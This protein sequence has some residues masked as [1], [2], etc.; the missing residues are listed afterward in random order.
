MAEGF[1]KELGE[2]VEKCFDPQEAVT[3]LKGLFGDRI[4]DRPDLID[5]TKAAYAEVRSHDRRISAAPL[6]GKSTSA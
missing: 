5:V 2:I 6:V 3:R 1:A 4:P